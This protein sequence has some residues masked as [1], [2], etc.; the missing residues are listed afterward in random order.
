MTKIFSYG[1]TGTSLFRLD[2][3]DCE[4]FDRKLRSWMPPASFD[5]H[6][7]LYDL[8]ML[9]PG[10]TADSFEGPAEVR[11]ATYLDHQRSWLGDRCP[12]GTLFF[13][14]PARMLDTAAANRFL[15]DEIGP[16]RTSL[17]GLMIIKP[18]DDP[19]SVE[20]QVARDGWSGFKVYHVFAARSDSFLAEP[21]E[22]L[23]DWAW[24]IADRRGLVIMLHM[25]LKRALA[26]ERNQRYIREHCVR[27][28]SAR[29]VLAH[30][31]RGFC[32]AHTVEGIDSLRG[33]DNVWFDTSAICEPA[34][35]EA[36]LRTFGTTRLLY[37]SDFPVSEAR[38][39]AM[40]LGDGFWWLYDNSVD[41]KGWQ[42]GTPTKVGIQSLLAI[43]QA[44]RTPLPASGERRKFVDQCPW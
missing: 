1:D 36:I 8:R 44:C 33:L 15:L 4:L 24:E 35:L 5:F 16:R 13:P 12:A 25:V 43:Q 27:Y 23:P 32:A 6:A 28:P 37:G 9:V 17:A 7:H 41:W 29:L 2:E 38:A 26:D 20:A 42:H 11:Y 10:S 21:G 22:F 31:A 34:A 19:D 39:H 18:T 30:A 3:S 40:S 14:F